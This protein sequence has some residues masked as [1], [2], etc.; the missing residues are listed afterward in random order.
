M[1]R[2]SLRRSVRFENTLG[3]QSVSVHCETHDSARIHSQKIALTENRFSLRCCDVLR[4]SLTGTRLPVIVQQRPPWSGTC[5]ASQ[6][7]RPRA[8]TRREWPH[9]IAHGGA[10]PCG[11]QCPSQPV[12]ESVSESASV[13]QDF[14]DTGMSI[15]WVGGRDRELRPC[16]QFCIVWT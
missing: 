1:L 9:C 4:F 16:A 5:A 13:T 14:V 3:S 2:C 7:L 12:S 11:I 6:S 15:S 10:V 8:A